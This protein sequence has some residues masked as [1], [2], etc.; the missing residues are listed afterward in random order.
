MGPLSDAIMIDCMRRER[1]ICATAQSHASKKGRRHS[2]TDNGFQRLAQRLAAWLVGYV[3]A[4][5]RF[6]QLGVL[7]TIGQLPARAAR[8][9][10]VV[11]LG[12][13]V[14]PTPASLVACWDLRL[15]AAQPRAGRA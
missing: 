11:P 3:P 6:R 8:V 15:L 9:V 14:V 12:P 10:A 13:P 4:N 2:S 7:P 5:G 1:W